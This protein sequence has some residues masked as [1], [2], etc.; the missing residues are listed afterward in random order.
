[1]QKAEGM[2]GSTRT[3]VEP[4]LRRF[5]RPPS[6]TLPLQK[7]LPL[8]KLLTLQKLLP[9]QIPTI[10]PLQKVA[11][12]M[13]GLGAQRAYLDES[14]HFVSMSSR[15]RQT[16]LAKGGPQQ[17]TNSDS[18]PTW[19]CA[20]GRRAQSARP[21]KT[22]IGQMEDLGKEEAQITRCLH[23]AVL[24]TTNR[25]KCNVWW[26]CYHNTNNKHS[27]LPGLPAGGRGTMQCSV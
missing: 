11:C 3:S 24:T 26:C 7:V 8:Q 2:G 19:S 13:V 12:C 27:P 5:G 16:Q 20:G 10:F 22:L 21:G 1:M 23:G 17:H 15:Y 18:M 4:H 6:K 14:P 9:L 25:I